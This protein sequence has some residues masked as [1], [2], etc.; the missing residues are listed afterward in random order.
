MRLR[1]VFVVLVGV[2]FLK[3]FPQADKDGDG[4]LSI[5]ELEAVIRQ[6]DVPK[7][8]VYAQKRV[9]GVEREMEIYFPK[10]HD[11][12]KRVFPGIVLFHGGRHPLKW[13]FAVSS[14]AGDILATPD[15][16]LKPLCSW[17]R[18]EGMIGR[19][20]EVSEPQGAIVK[21]TSIDVAI[22]S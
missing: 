10:R 5:K 22:A 12:S 17:S 13:L 19:H 15:F 18:P 8:K 14:L 1:H 20:A 2:L 4:V 21:R 3:R 6:V 16:L 7:G 11:A 9:D